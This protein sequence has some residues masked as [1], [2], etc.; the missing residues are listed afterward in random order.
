MAAP[1]PGRATAVVLALVLL[2]APALGSPRE[3][4][5]QD[6][7]KS[8]VV[9][10]AALAAALLFLFEQRRRN[11]PLRWHGVLWLPLLLMAY[12][13]GSMAWAHTYLAGVE[14]IRW[15]L[16]A[17]IAWL[18]LNS[19]TRERLP[20]LA[21]C[22]LG[23]ALA[24]SLWAMAQFWGGLTLFPQGPQPSSTFVN[25]NF[26]AEFAVCALPFGAL[27]LARARM[28]SVV[29][30][31]AAVLGVVTTAL[32][33]TG[34]RSALIALWLQ[35][36]VV[37]PLIAWRCRGALAWPQWSKGLRLAVVPVFLGTV[38]GLGAIPTDNPHILEEGHGRTP[39]A[40]GLARTQSIGPKDHSLGLR[41]VMWRA[42]ARVIADRPLSGVGAGAWESEV[43]RYQAEGAQLETDYYV[44]NEFLQL[45]AE[46][47]L[48]A[49]A[50]L[51]A[52]GAWL[53]HAA[54]RTWQATGT[55]GEE[56][57]PWRATLLC[58][59]LALLVVS[60][61]GFPWRLAATGALFALCLGALAASDARLG[62]AGRW[63][64]RP[65]AWSPARGRV[66]I[67][68]AAVCMA[69]AVYITHQA[70]E[71]EGKLVRAARL[72]L[73][74][75]GSGDPAD[76]RHAATK[77]RVL[78][79]A[80]EGIAI[81]RHYRKVTPMIADETARWGDWAGAVEIWESVLSS[82]PYIVAILLNTARGHDALGH[83][84]LAF[85]YLERARRL[86]PRAPV[87]RSVE[88]LMLAR[89]G[90]EREAMDRARIAMEEGTVDYDLV[91]AYFILAS[92]AGDYPLARSLLEERMRQ[93]PESRVQGLVQLGNLYAEGF[94]DPAKALAAYRLAISTA[95][96]QVRQQLLAQ[97]PAGYRAQLAAP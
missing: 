49:W 62:S 7:L 47:G 3:E 86:Q 28:S 82:R 88:V 25:R 69:L 24:A 40:R 92:R 20:L 50:F 94:K 34:T 1:Q 42:T 80:H 26:F 19:F 41:M 53:L 4:L 17:L 91:D 64:A 75:T 83:R 31:L 37:W 30:L 70:V 87:V 57:R 48:V 43:P 97:V 45:V 44:H 33:M 52:L 21:W 32:L 6:T 90:Q 38:L 93:W 12:A 8:A 77:A 67:A 54:L 59:L 85:A 35:L 63:L 58:S 27:L 5:L 81:N 13:L 79:L 60:N 89:D 95:S 46:Y 56:E 39:L 72:A 73:G 61:I 55:T 84:E 65:L 16:V 11:E 74:I 23:G 2:L 22:A 36:L 9:A 51:L 66:A 29:V 96:P 68:A 71:A 18:A 10:F 14:A 76:P 78:A 15:F